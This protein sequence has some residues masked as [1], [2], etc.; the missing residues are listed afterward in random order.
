VGS[1][2]LE[3]KAC[4]DFRD[5]YEIS[6]RIFPRG[7]ASSISGVEVFSLGL[8]KKIGGGLARCLVKRECL[9]DR[10]VLTSSRVGLNQGTNMPSESPRKGITGYQSNLG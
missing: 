3:K 6:L 4:V 10:R 7:N 1:L 5:D 9:R 2:D 8:K